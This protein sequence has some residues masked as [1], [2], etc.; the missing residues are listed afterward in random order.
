MRVV[1]DAANGV[2]NFGGNSISRKYLEHALPVDGIEGFGK[3]YENC[4]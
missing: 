4:A 3:V 2:D 1:V